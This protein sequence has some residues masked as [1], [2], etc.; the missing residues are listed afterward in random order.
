MGL[1]TLGVAES[2]GLS[3]LSS[4]ARTY[5]HLAE[6]RRD[7]VRELA[8]D[9]WINKVYPS[10]ECWIV[11]IVARL[12]PAG[13][14]LIFA[15]GDNNVIS[16]YSRRPYFGFYEADPDVPA[17]PRQKHL[18]LD[19]VNFTAEQFSLDLDLQKGDL[20]FFNNLTVFH[21]ASAGRGF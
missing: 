1:I 8:K 5:N 6:T 20:E 3:Q 16:S 2:G 15:V 17:L 13:K 18:A 10:G 11:Y 9:D 4:V 14:P 7:I 19:A 12:R 21:G